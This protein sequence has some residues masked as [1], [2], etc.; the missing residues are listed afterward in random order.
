MNRVLGFLTGR[1]GVLGSWASVARVVAWAAMWAVVVSVVVSPRGPEPGDRKREA[2]A[3][4]SD[5]RYLGPVTK[6]D[7]AG[8]VAPEQRPDDPFVVA[9]IGGSDVKLREVSVAGEV[10]TRIAAFGGRP[11]QIDAYTLLA[12]RP[13]DALRAVDSAV[14][15]GAD[16]IVLSINASW[17]TDEWSM[18]EWQNLDVAN[19]GSLL[20]RP[21]TWPWAVAL[22][23]PADVS[24]RITR[25][26]LATVEAQNRLNG[27]AQD[28]L[29]ALD[30]ITRPDSEVGADGEADPD[31]LDPRLPGDAES[32]WLVAEYG[33]QILDDTTERVATQVDGLADD[34]PIADA[35]NL[36]LVQDIEAAGVPAYLY[37]T[38]FSPESLADPDLAAAAAQVEAYWTAI[39]GKVRSPLVTIE[40]GQLTPLFADRASYFDLVHMADAGPFADVLVTELCANWRLAHPDRECS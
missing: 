30:I 8:F 7:F 6:G 23:S 33:P 1:L 21:S 15:N 24:W 27:E 4:A 14:A 36:R 13:L 39:A 26:A 18:R 17:L 40:A 32:F 35:L 2:D 3:P 38:P 37:V 31:D 19:V 12:P 29:D 10:S 16:A 11:V 25:G 34:S 9:W 20:E 5:V 28:A 22:T